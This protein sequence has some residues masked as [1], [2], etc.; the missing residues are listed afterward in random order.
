M[1]FNEKRLAWIQQFQNQ[2][3]V[4][5]PSCNKC[6]FTPFDC[7]FYFSKNGQITICCQE[8][9]NKQSSELHNNSSYEDPLYCSP[10]GQYSCVAILLGGENDPEVAYECNYCGKIYHNDDS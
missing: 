3:T 8:C 10:C 4:T 1:S 7:S 5:C 9:L 2:F 6:T